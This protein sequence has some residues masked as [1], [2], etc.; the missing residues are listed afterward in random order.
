MNNRIFVIHF[1]TKKCRIT[2]IVVYVPVEPTDRDSSNPYELYLQ[3]QERIDR[4]LG[5]N[6]EV[7]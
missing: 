2:E 4:V 1:M 7:L 3:L 5:R 6:M